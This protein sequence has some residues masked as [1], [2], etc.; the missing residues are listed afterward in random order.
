MGRLFSELSEPLHE[1]R[2]GA[3]ERLRTV[4]LQI[5]STE[6]QTKLRRGLLDSLGQAVE[7]GL[8]NRE[9]NPLRRTGATEAKGERTARRFK[10]GS[11]LV[12]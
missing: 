12:R 5:Q 1:Q 8:S 11:N 3:V 10:T 7:V 6:F 4:G 2:L 9:S